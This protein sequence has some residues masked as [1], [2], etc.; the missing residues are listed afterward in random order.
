M[1]PGLAIVEKTPVRNIWTYPL[2]ETETK[3]NHSHPHLLQLIGIS[4]K[5]S[6]LPFLVFANCAH[7]LKQFAPLCRNNFSCPA[8]L[9]SLSSHMLLLLK[10][11]SIAN[12][13]TDLLHIVSVSYF[14]SYIE[15]LRSIYSS[16]APFM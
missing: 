11:G 6:A 2:C 10:N 5:K 14:F 9:R 3:K 12:C 7:F 8:D 16:T 1:A 15:L 4:D 13:V